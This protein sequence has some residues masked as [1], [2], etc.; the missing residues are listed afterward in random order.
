[1]D[2]RTNLGGVRAYKN[3]IEI[4][5]IAATITVPINSATM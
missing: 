5:G 3:P 1:M 4:H 2:P